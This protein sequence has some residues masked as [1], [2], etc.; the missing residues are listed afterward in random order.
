MNNVA[1]KTIA[2]SLALVLLAGFSSCTYGPEGTREPARG[3]AERGVTGTGETT[4]GVQVGSLEDL[5]SGQ[6]MDYYNR[7]FSEMGYTIENA[8]RINSRLIYDLADQ[9]DQ[10]YRVELHQDPQSTEVTRINVQERRRTTGQAAREDEEFLRVREQIRQ[11]VQ[12]GEPVITYLPRLEEIGMVT[13]FDR[14]DDR[15]TVDLRINDNEYTVEMQLNP[16]NHRVS[17]VEVH[18][19]FW[20]I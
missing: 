11:A 6:S 16:S 12:P 8:R 15:A 1:P 19:D 5:E 20:S 14:D 13:E 3:V 18:E 9:N 4:P 2:T 10:H 17:S 7:Q